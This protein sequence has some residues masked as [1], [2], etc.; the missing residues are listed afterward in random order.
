MSKDACEFL[1]RVRRKQRGF[2]L[3]FLVWWVCVVVFVF[4]VNGV[5]KGVPDA[6][7]LA[8]FYGSA[9]LLYIPA[10]KLFKLKCPYCGGSA[11]ALPFLRYKFMYCRACGERIECCK[12]GT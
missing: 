12:E 7:V 2:W 11:R 9:L 4:I 5:L 3:A 10:Y 1:E 8:I 6:L